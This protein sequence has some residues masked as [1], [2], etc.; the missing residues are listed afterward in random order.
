MDTNPDQIQIACLRCAKPIVATTQ[1]VEEARANSLGLYCQTCVE[2]PTPGIL[3]RFLG[4]S[5]KVGAR[6]FGVLVTLGGLRMAY[7]G[8]I[9]LVELN[10]DITPGLVL[11]ILGYVI[12]LYVV[13]KIAD[14]LLRWK[15][16]HAR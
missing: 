11:V 15:P 10:L 4:G 6:F 2:P 12:L 16:K 8:F 1:Q 13:F 5:A 9:T 3:S 14:Y 7:L